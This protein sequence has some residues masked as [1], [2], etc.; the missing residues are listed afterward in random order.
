MSDHTSAATHPHALGEKPHVGLSTLFVIYFVLLGLVL[1]TLL[2]AKL[3]LGRANF[4]IAMSIAAA[5][6]VLIV[7]YFMHVRYSPKLTWVFSVAAFFWLVVLVMGLL[8][9]YFT[10]VLTVPGK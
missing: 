6:A 2:A 1:L 10:R 5:K 3:D 9:D 4:L 8:M 7:V